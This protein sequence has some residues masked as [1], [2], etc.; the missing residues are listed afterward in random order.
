MNTERTESV[1]GMPE[2]RCPVCGIL[3]RDLWE[4]GG[5]FDLEESGADIECGGCE[6]VLRL[7]CRVIVTYILTPQERQTANP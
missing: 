5:P 2:V 7:T 3:N 1:L 6:A 4:H